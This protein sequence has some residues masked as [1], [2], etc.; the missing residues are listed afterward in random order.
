MDGCL[1]YNLFTLSDY[2]NIFSRGVCVLR[3]MKRGW[4]SDLC[5]D[6]VYECT[7]SREHT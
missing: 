7:V 5:F 4:I 6:D 2:D 3:R 1:L